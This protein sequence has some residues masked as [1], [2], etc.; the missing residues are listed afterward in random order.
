M[1][2]GGIRA[3]AWA[4]TLTAAACVEHL[5]AAIDR[6]LQRREPP[7]VRAG[8]DGRRPRSAQGQTAN[9]AIIMSS[10]FGWRSAEQFLAVFH[11]G[12]H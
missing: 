4:L 5:G 9:A 8:H 2:R 12:N 6:L 11:V 7:A 3:L 1:S 10:F